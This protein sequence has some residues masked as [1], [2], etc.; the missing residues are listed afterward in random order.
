MAEVKATKEKILKDKVAQL[1]NTEIGKKVLAKMNKDELE[2]LDADEIMAR[3]V[4]ELEKEKKELQIRLKSQEKKVDHLERAKRLEEIPLLKEEFVKFKDD[5]R[6]VWIEQEKERIEGE[7][8]ERDLAVLSSERL[9]RMK[10]DKDKYLENLLNERK[11]AFDR[12]LKEF[13]KLR[14]DEREKER[15]RERSRD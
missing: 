6:E 14:E 12:K 9:G 15:E 7:K 8:K 1:D 10:E 3:Q 5:A 13:T 11:Q 4:E 2:N